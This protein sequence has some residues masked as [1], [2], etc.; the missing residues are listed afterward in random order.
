[1]EFWKREAERDILHDEKKIVFGE[2]GDVP[3]PPI[4]IYSFY[5]RT[6]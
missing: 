3:V 2:V 6:P 1:M 4:H 5:Q